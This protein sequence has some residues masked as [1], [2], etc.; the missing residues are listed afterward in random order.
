MPIVSITIKEVQ[1]LLQSQ[2]PLPKDY[3]PPRLL[4]NG[5]G[6]DIAFEKQ[7]TGFGEKI[8]F[9]CPICGSRRTKLY[10]CQHR[11]VCRG[12]I[13]YNPYYSITHTTKNGYENLS[14]RMRGF[15]KKHDIDLKFPFFYMD[16]PKPKWKHEERWCEI[17]AILQALENMRNQAI[18][19]N[20]RYKTIVIQSV[21]Q[22]KNM[23]LY[24]CELYDLYKYFYD[25]DEGYLMYPGNKEKIQV[26][27]IT[28]SCTPYQNRVL[29]LL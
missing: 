11:L 3:Y 18:F 7:R 25:W 4:V 17:L 20:K 9:K 16:Y 12:C 15:A 28:S 26:K 8:F 5:E 24:A 14:Y 13:T 1:Q 21:L 2:Q 22:G 29:G 19:F 27:G 23:F 6:M 10:V